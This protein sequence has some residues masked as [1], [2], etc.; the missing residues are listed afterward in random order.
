MIA[1]EL[2]Y[3]FLDDVIIQEIS[4]TAKVTTQTVKS[5]ERTAGGKLPRLFSGLINRNYIDRL[6]GDEKGYLDEEIYVEVLKKVLRELAE[7]DNAVLMGRGG[8]YILADLENAYHLL[9]VS[10]MENRIN[11][12]QRYYKLSTDKAE[13]AVRIGE[14]RRINLYSRMGKEDYNMPHHYH[15]IL[16]MSKLSL[17]QALKQV[18]VLV[19]GL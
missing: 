6:I 17:Q 8:Q 13:A 18:C 5:M 16:N 10:S 4:R 14:K 3:R 9:L 2:E 19:R 7:Q 15:L 1:K 11:F 12:M